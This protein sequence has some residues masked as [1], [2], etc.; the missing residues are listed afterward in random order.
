MIKLKIFRDK[1]M[2]FPD[3]LNYGALIEDGIVLNKDGSLLAGWFFRGDDLSSSTNEERNTVSQRINHVFSRLDTGWMSHIDVVR[4][5]TREYPHAD[6]SSFPDPITKLIDNE[7]RAQFESEGIHFESIY[8]L[9]L[10]YLPPLSS[11]SKVADLMMEGGKINEGKSRSKKNIAYFTN[12]ITE[13]EDQLKSFLLIQRMKSIPYL[14]R[15]NSKQVS[16]PL[17][18]YLNFCATGENHMIN[19]PSIP[20]YLDMLIGSQEFIGGLNPKVGE[21]NIIAITIDGFP[22]QSEAGILALLDQIPVQYR[23]STRFIYMDTEEAIDHLKKYRRKWQ[24]KVRGFADQLFKTTNGVIDQDALYMV[25]DTEVAISEASRNDVVFGYFT[26]TVILMGENLDDLETHAKMIRKE[27][28]NLGF[29]CKLETI[30]TIEAFLGSLPGHGVQNVRRPLIHTLNL[31]DMLPLSSIW[32]GREINP[33]PFYP[34]E[35][36]ALMHCA[37]EGSTPFRLNLHVGDLGHTLIFGPTGAGKSTLLALIAAQFRRYPN[38]SLFVFDKGNSMLP[39][40]LAAGGDHY[41]IGGEEGNLQFCPLSKIETDQDQAWAEEWIEILIELQQVKVS[42]AD[43]NEIHSAMNSLRNSESKTL[44]DFVTN[45][46]NTSLQETLEHYTVSG[47]MGG[48]LDSESDNLEL[49]TFMT[50]EIEEL[51]NL[52]DKNLIPVL[53]YV[54]HCIE[55]RLKGQ[56]S[57]IILD[58]AWLMLSHSVFRTKIREWLKVLRKS[59]CAVILATQSLSDAANSGIMD[60]LKESCPTKILLPNSTAKEPGSR[61]FYEMMGLNDQQIRIISDALPKRQYYYLSSEG[62]R[63][64][65]L[66]LGPIALSFV[67]A[68]S[69]EDI[70]TIKSLRDTY[71]HQWPMKWLEARKVPYEQYL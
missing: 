61:E 48:L 24:Q 71:H 60:V 58:E 57:L 42:P 4:I 30:N 62:R 46:M 32:P 65:E 27:I 5:P 34:K 37:T 8:V 1:A 22:Y 44:T 14:D 25:D 55:K 39:L 49:S 38:S 70:K 59:N 13:I 63:L 26:S 56:P 10:T 51:M 64:F 66:N 33:C 68:S 16:E 11:K 6:D 21:K 45:L 20:M 53:L 69:K 15:E 9:T 29:S 43:R 17:L 19:L 52:G 54:F 2:G 12:M 35:S 67:G 47:S 3:L 50:F 7:R 23:W 28:Q 41:E 36:P 40:T 31:A 18:Q